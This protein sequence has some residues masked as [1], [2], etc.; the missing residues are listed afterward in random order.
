MVYTLRL[1]RNALAGLRVQ[2]SPPVPNNAGNTMVMYTL[3]NAKGHYLSADNDFSRDKVVKT[4]R[5]FQKAKFFLHPRLLLEGF[6]SIRV[7]VRETVIRNVTNTN[8]V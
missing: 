8:I 7:E 3:K 1:E 4:T 2:I 6:D 5:H